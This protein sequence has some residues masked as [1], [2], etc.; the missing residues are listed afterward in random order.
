MD[1]P[2]MS[3]PMVSFR[4]EFQGEIDV[5]FLDDLF[6]EMMKLSSFAKVMDITISDTPDDERGRAQ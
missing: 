2:A 3:V 1:V 6:H 5:A 4:V